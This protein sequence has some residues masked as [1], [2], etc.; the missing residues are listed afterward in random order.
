[1]FYPKASE[2]Y[3][4]ETMNV[5]DIGKITK[6]QAEKYGES[7]YQVQGH[8]GSYGRRSG[9]KFRTKTVNGILHIMRIS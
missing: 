3:H 8:V 5:G 6:D 7:F 1:M 2:R 9:K 4:L